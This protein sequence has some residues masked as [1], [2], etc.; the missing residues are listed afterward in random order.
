MRAPISRQIAMEDIKQ[1]LALSFTYIRTGGTHLYNGTRVTH[2]HTNTH[3][4]H[5]WL[6]LPNTFIIGKRGR[7]SMPT[8]LELTGDEMNHRRRKLYFE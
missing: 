6:G 2:I 1:H 3:T 8:L 4:H 7:L 5:R